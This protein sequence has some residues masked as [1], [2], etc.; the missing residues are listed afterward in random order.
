MTP[1]ESMALAQAVK[2]FFLLAI[3][4]VVAAIKWGLLRIYEL[5]QRRRATDDRRLTKRL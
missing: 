2:S 1:G 4:G 3:A 5:W